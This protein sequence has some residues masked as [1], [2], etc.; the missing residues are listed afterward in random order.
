MKSFYSL[1]FRGF[2]IKKKKSENSFIDNKYI[3]ENNKGFQLNFE[4]SSLKN[5]RVS[6]SHSVGDY[7]T[8]K[9][10]FKKSTLNNNQWKS[11]ILIIS[12]NFLSTVSGAKIFLFRNIFCIIYQNK[13]RFINKFQSQWHFA[14]VLNNTRTSVSRACVLN[15]FKF[16]L[17]VL[18]IV[19]V[20]FLS[21]IFVPISIYLTSFAV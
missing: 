9:F 8:F 7:Q 4:T 6:L 20:L 14:S 2:R 15:I 13:N 21:A 3:C 18:N 5:I 19:F 17:F 10:F 16:Y 12:R 1:R 11:F